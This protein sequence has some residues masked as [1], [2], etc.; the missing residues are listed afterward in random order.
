MRVLPHGQD[1]RF[2]GL[3]RPGLIEARSL[4]LLASAHAEFP[5]LYRPGL[6]EACSIGAGARVP[7]AGFRGFTAPASLKRAHCLCLVLLMP[8]FPG[9]YRPGLIEASC[10]PSSSRRSSP[11]PGLY[12]P[13]LIE[14]KAEHA[15]RDARVQGFRGF[16]AP[17]SLKPRLLRRGG[18]EVPRVSGALPPRPH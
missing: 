15:D 6:I 12:R 17:A 2:P 10:P 4:P 11:F 1:P 16:T 14:A 18:P 13:G 5:G 3:Y 9:L 7:F 8:R